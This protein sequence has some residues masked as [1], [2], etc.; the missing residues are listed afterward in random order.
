M[1]K[2]HFALL[3]GTFL[4]FFHYY[5]QNG[6]AVSIKLAKADLDKLI[7]TGID[8]TSLG[9]DAKKFSSLSV[10]DLHP[11]ELAQQVSLSLSLSLFFVF[12]LSLFF[13]F[14]HF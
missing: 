4:S 9:T 12:S 11:A 1:N 13:M 6:A 3:V 10:Q 5:E 8:H 7:T 2:V 14:S